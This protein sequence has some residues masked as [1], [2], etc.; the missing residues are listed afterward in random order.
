M[1]PVGRLR[2]PP[3]GFTVPFT[4]LLVSALAGPIPTVG[5]KRAFGLGLRETA[6][7]SFHFCPGILL[8]TPQ[9]ELLYPL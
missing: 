2:G 9:P 4:D 3:P 5:Q 6:L 8:V 1:G 7:Y